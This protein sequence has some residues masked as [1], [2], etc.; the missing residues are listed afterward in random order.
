MYVVV[1]HWV[2]VSF[3]SGNVVVERQQAVLLGFSLSAALICRYKQCLE[4]AF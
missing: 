1:A 3:H 4:Q 2:A